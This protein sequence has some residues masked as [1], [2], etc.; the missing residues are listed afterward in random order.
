M[1]VL[2]LAHAGMFWMLKVSVMPLGP[3]AV[4][5]KLYT[6]PAVTP[7]G[8]VP[9]MVGGLAG[10]GLETVMLK[11][12]SALVWKPSVT[13]I[14]MPATVPGCVGVPD[15]WPV[16]ALNVAHVGAFCA[17][18]VKGVPSAALVVGWNE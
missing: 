9:E 11:A 3:D 13:L 7:V 17:E 10:L 12:A 15:N 14:T 4:G 8:G 16:V 6:E 5:V 2:K 1:E 18:N